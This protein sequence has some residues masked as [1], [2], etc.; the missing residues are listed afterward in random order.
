MMLEVP[1]RLKTMRPAIEKLL[2]DVDARCRRASDGR[3][4]DCTAFEALVR[5]DCAAI[6]REAHG[7]TLAALDVDAAH[8]KIGGALHARVGRHETTFMT[9]VGGVSVTRSLYRKTGERNGRVV[10][11]VAMRAGCVAGEW[12]PGAAQQMAFLLQQGTAREA[13]QTAKQ[14]GRLP[15][16]RCS[17]DRVGHAV[18]ARYLDQHESIEQRL[19]EA[20]ELPEGATGV[21]VSLD[22]ISVPIEEARPRPVGRPHHAA[23]KRPC[24]RA[25]RMAYCGTVTIHNS[26]GEALHTIRYGTMPQGDEQGLVESMASDVLAV[27]EKK[28]SLTV[29][30]LCDG[31]PEMWTLLDAEF[32]RESFGRRTIHHRVDFWHLVEKLAAAAQVLFGDEAAHHRTRWAIRLLNSERAASGIL[33]ELRRAGHEHVR[34]GDTCPVHDAITYI[35]NH[36]DKMNYADARERGL[37]I[38]SGQVEATCKSLFALR[39]KRPGSRWKHKTGE[40]IVHLRALAL[41]DR[42]T[43]AMDITLRARPLQIRRAA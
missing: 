19:I 2:R 27:L 39:F 24:T 21:S 14:L 10:D 20:F 23:P 3:S 31:S 32:D 37:P 6:E 13:E 7:V 43:H 25:W 17:F 1:E 34:V 35:E 8:V 9:Q 15:Y 36:G 29:S 40:H 22:R 30:L 38:G 5:D 12:L 28:P 4:F 33:G 16:S 42:W 41:S 11:P 18:G 26:R